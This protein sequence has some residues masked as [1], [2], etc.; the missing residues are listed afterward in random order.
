MKI[1][2]VYDW[3]YKWGGAERL[4]LELHN[5]WPDAPIYTSVYDKKTTPWADK[6]K[7]IPSFLNKFPFAKEKH[8]LY[9]LLTPI[10][11]ESHDFS[12]YDVVLSVTSSDSKAVLTKPEI[13]HVCYC[14]TPPRYL[15][16]HVGDYFGRWSKGLI[17]LLRS[18]DMVFSRRPDCYLA[19]SETA[20]KRIKSIYSQDSETIYPPVDSRYWN[21]NPN[22]EREDY[23]LLVSRLVKYKKI[24]LVIEAFNNL[25]L[26]LRIIG[27][28]AQYSYL[29][30]IAKK[31][32]EFLG[33]L[34]DEKLL[35]Y[36]QRCRALMFASEEDFGLTMVEAQLCGCPVIAYA[37]GGASEIILDEK[38]GVLF[39]AQ[40]RESIMGAVGK[41]ENLLFDQKTCRKNGLR[42][43]RKL[44]R[45]KISITIQK[46]WEMHKKHLATI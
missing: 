29:K 46:K 26:P 5:L 11:F 38:T 36:Y 22:A 35:D 10:C 12:D 7:I 31:N 15:W 16:T 21:L 2:F 18:R 37:R 23:Y 4:L 40:T 42:F 3:I 19:V 30:S 41:F 8:E 34:T 6:I 39:S 43:D 1:A 13:L 33:R 17:S 27:E 32:V 45:N 20:R 25:G 24:E 28:G 44:F 9:T 14:L